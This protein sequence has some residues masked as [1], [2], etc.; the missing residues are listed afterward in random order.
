MKCE[1][2]GAVTDDLETV[3][4][5]L[6]MALQAVSHLMMLDAEG[7]ADNDGINISTLFRYLAI[8]LDN[9]RNVADKA[10]IEK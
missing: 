1:K 6:V 4:L 5:E 8:P 2:C 9:A 3:A 10:S 7:E